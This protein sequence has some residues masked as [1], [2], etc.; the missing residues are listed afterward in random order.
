[1][2]DYTDEMIKEGT[3]YE[4]MV[5]TKGWQTLKDYV[6][7]QLKQFQEHSL[8]TGFKSMD[9]YQFSRGQAFGLYNLINEVDSK[10]QHLNRWRDKQRSG[11]N[12][13][14]TNSVSNL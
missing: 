9:E 5:N 11:E 7:E 8:A 10:L 12:T 13:D 6:D 2:I 1:M 3:A 14:N 4:V